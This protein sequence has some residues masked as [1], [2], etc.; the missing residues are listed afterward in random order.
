M[1]Q[2]VLYRMKRF[3][4]L[5]NRTAERAGSRFRRNQTTSGAISITMTG[6]K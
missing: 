1:C 3:A 4:K 5:S 2:T 6:G